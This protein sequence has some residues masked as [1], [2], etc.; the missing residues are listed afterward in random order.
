MR[1][2][3][4]RSVANHVHAQPQ[5]LEGRVL[6]S[7]YYVATNGDDANPGTALDQ[8]LKTIQEAAERA[9]AGDTVLVRGGTYRETIKP[10]RSGTA[11]DPITFRPYND[12][13]VTV[14]G[15]DPVTGWS[16][17]S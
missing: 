7:T 15:A 12:E 17:H 2:N 5:P 10:A 8:P 6:L 14:S 4:R 3:R 11:D 9:R 13:A 16:R 1:S